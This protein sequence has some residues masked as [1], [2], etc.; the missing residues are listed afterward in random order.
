MIRR[1]GPFAV[2]IPPLVALAAAW[3]ALREAPWDTASLLA[4]RESLRLAAEAAPVV[5]LAVFLT[6]YFVI[7]SSGLPVGPPM[8]LIAGFLFGRWIGT[9]AI[10]V[11]ATAGALVVHAAA[12]LS[13]G[14]PL[15]ERL[16]RRAGPLYALAAE[17]LRANAFGYLL[18]MRLVPFFPFFLVNI[19]AG[20][21][22]IPART[23]ALATLVGRAP[24]AFLYVSLGEELGQVSRLDELVQPRVLLLLLGMA[25]LAA[26][27]VA[28]AHRRGRLSSR[29]GRRSPQ[30]GK[31][32]D[33]A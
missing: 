4:R 5:T 1:L 26:L 13:A 25:A 31:E 10:L 11:A 17:D 28:L 3:L 6:T 18:V 27:P 2:L 22:G 24:A 23:F 9:G 21:V 16:Q 30:D 14:T 8:S 7:I 33:A 15:G 20:I 32:G 19:L 12:C 29:N